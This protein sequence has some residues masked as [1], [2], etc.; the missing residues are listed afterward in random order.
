MKTTMTKTETTM[1]KTENTIKRTVIKEE[2]S[3][4]IYIVMSTYNGEK[5][6]RPQIDSILA[7]TWQNWKL[8]I[9]DDGSTDQT[10]S[11]LEEYQASDGRI[12]IIYGEN[13]G[14]SRSFFMALA[15]CGEDGYYAFSDQD[16]IWKPEKLQRSVRWLQAKEEEDKG[17][18]YRDSGRQHNGEKTQLLRTEEKVA[19][20]ESRH[21]EQEDQEKPLLYYSLW[22][23]IDEEE[24]SIGV[25]SPKREE[26]TF[27]R[28]MTGCFGA[29]MSMVINNRCRE[30][31]LRC[32]GDRMDAHDWAAGIIALGMGEVHVDH[33]V[34][35]LHRV[36]SSNVSY[37]SPR[38]QVEWFLATLTKES[39]LRIRNREFYEKLG[40]ELPPDKRKLAEEFGREH[41]TVS[42]Q[43]H[44]VF[45][46][47]PWRPSLLSEISMRLLMLAGRI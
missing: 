33:H 25:R 24:K 26:V 42:T 17:E 7:Q 10:R 29:G 34:S 14:F 36:T 41:L 40:E 37:S 4:L 12:Q 21:R 31:M 5:V 20:T 8:V 15:A 23:G 16:D 18:K 35:A 9:R 6:I 28:M 46:P 11:I 32:D 30:L 2:K 38:K 1:A 13:V 47:R 45:D 19:L 27:R 3:P 22:E 44:K 39:N 43:L